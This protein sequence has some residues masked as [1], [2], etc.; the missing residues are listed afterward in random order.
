ME[1]KFLMDYANM[2][3]Y[4]YF[5]YFCYCI[6]NIFSFYRNAEVPGSNWD[7]ETD[8]RSSNDQTASKLVAV[9]NLL[10]TRDEEN[11]PV[12]EKSWET[13]KGEKKQEGQGRKDSEKTG[14]SRYEAEGRPL[15]VISS[16]RD[17]QQGMEPPGDE[18]IRS[19]GVPSEDKSKTQRGGR[20]PKQRR[21][22]FRQVAGSMQGA[23]KGDDT[24]SADE[25]LDSKQPLTPSVPITARRATERG[26]GN[27]VEQGKRMEEPRY[28]QVNK[29]VDLKNGL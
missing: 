17:K 20:F 5:F 13:G 28:Q 9:G 21:K 14:G 10:L 18:S 8:G 1:D 11:P 2:F 4:L 19:N 6:L 15:E 16:A 12:H 3:I 22:Q 29:F 26:E 7:R 25:T 27:R 24:K 23:A